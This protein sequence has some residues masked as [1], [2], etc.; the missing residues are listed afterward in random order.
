VRPVT[1]RIVLAEDHFL[2]REGTTALLSGVDGLEVVATAGDLDELL[3]AVGRH[4]P[5]VVLT[6]IRMP[7][8]HTTEGITA[9]RHIRAVYPG[10]GVLVLSQYADADYAYQLLEDGAAGLGYLLKERV[11]D[12][13]DI[14]EAVRQVAA[15]GSVLDPRVVEALVD[16]QRRSASPLDRLTKREREVL[17]HMARGFN[18]AGI[19]TAMVITERAVENY[20]NTVFGKLGLAEEPSVHRR[21]MA[22]LTLLR[23]ADRTRAAATG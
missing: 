11:A 10:I 3:A 9:A 15:G 23:E 22:V 20:I 2:I 18:N 13:A 21:V 5:D 16:R 4:R 8:T 14:V 19:A 6:D 17:E 12:L 1:Q 7:P